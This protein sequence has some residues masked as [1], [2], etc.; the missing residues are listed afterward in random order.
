VID[1]VSPYLC[2]M[3]ISSGRIELIFPS[4]SSMS[5]SSSGSYRHSPCPSS[6]EEEFVPSLVLFHQGCCISLMSSWSTN[7]FCSCS[8]NCYNIFVF[9]TPYDF[10]RHSLTSKQKSSKSSIVLSKSP[11]I[12]STLEILYSTD[13][14]FLSFIVLYFPTIT[15]HPPSSSPQGFSLVV[16]NNHLQG[17]LLCSSFLPPYGRNQTWCLS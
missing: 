13:T 1:E 2:F 10:R 14:N 16:H 8:M 9:V 4:H 5:Q 15:P 3:Y 6:L 11:H 17:I 7:G 12:S